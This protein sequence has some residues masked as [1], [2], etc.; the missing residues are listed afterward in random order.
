MTTLQRQANR[1]LAQIT[2]DAPWGI[3]LPSIRAKNRAERQRASA[4]DL[5]A[6]HLDVSQAV[7]LHDGYR[8]SLEQRKV[9]AARI[10]DAVMALTRQS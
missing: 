8:S 5:V 7:A 10:V 1:I 6:D 9:H 2:P 3:D 4:I